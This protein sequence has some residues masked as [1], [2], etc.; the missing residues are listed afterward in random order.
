M[1]QPTPVA[2][3]RDGTTDTEMTLILTEYDQVKGEQRN[4]IQHRDGLVYTTIAA[5]GAVIAA[6]IGQHNAAVLLLLPPVAIVLG[7][8]YLANDE[9]IGNANRYVR[10]QLSP[11]AAEI[12]GV[13]QVFGWE[14]YH[15][16]GVFRRAR[17][18][19]QLAVDLLAFNVLPAAALVGFWVVG[20]CP[21]GLV[22]VSVAEALLLTGFGWLVWLACQPLAGHDTQHAHL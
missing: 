13:A 17:W 8:K 4:R 19:V 1:A 18:L 9:K 22:V 6:T 5:M 12:A 3:D 7:W 20:P 15:R 2:D 21:A 11:R 10:E 16:T 14:S